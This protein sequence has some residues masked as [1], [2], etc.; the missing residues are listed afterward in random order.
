MQT[1]SRGHPNQYKLF[2]VFVNDANGNLHNRCS[3][4]CRPLFSITL[5]N[6]EIKRPISPPPPPSFPLALTV[7]GMDQY[8][9]KLCTKTSVRISTGARLIDLI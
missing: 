8:R 3:I 6:W 1:N 7:V 9:Y 5:K 2:V 4:N